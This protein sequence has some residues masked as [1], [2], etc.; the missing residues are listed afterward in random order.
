[1]KGMNMKGMSTK[2]M[3]SMKMTKAACA[4]MTAKMSAQPKSAGGGRPKTQK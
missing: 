4:S 3:G 2:G 1:M